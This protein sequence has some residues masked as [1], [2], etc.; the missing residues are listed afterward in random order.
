MAAVKQISLTTQIKA[1]EYAISDIVPHWRATPA[2]RDLAIEQL[3]AAGETLRKLQEEPDG[4][5]HKL[6][7][8]AATERGAR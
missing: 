8:D 5:K 1:I 3:R 4:A 7:R 6:G 2:L